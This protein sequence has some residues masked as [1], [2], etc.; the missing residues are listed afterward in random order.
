[1]YALYEI[2]NATHTSTPMAPFSLLRRSPRGRK[3]IG[4]EQQQNS[5][6]D[7]KSSSSTL[8][9]EDAR[10]RDGSP[11]ATTGA[12]DTAS[13]DGET[14]GRLGF[15]KDLL[16]TLRNRLTGRSASST[17]QRGAPQPRSQNEVSESSSEPLRWAATPSRVAVFFFYSLFSCPVHFL[18]HTLHSL[19]ALQ[20]SCAAAICS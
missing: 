2:A 1:M 10:H 7:V 19:L 9:R 12:K 16:H 6:D 20:H 13:N 3:G 11:A 17:S 15:N 5:G 4:T 18:P 8:W 14:R